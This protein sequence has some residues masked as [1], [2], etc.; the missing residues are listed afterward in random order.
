MRNL[1]L[2]EMPC[3]A[4]R[5]HSLQLG[6]WPG[7]APV[8]CCEVLKVA[9]IFFGRSSRVVKVDSRQTRNVRD[10]VVGTVEG[11]STLSLHPQHFGYCQHAGH[12]GK[13]TVDGGGEE[14]RRRKRIE[15]RQRELVPMKE[16]LPPWRGNCRILAQSAVRGTLRKWPA[17]HASGNL[18]PRRRTCAHLARTSGEDPMKKGRKIMHGGTCAHAGTF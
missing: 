9:R 13:E 11:Q 18:C 6:D 2:E 4:M 14:E 5:A 12:G 17:N 8:V 1:L 10:R 3:Q 16:N 15:R 7:V